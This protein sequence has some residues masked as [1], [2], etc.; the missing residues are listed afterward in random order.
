MVAGNKV[1]FSFLTWG[2][3]LVTTE[4]FSQAASYLEKEIEIHPSSSEAH[5]LLGKAYWGMGRIK[6]AKAAWERAASL[7]PKLAP[8]VE[9]RLARLNRLQKLLIISNEVN[10]EEQVPPFL[11][12]DLLSAY[13]SRL[14]FTISPRLSGEFLSRLT[15]SLDALAPLALDEVRKMSEA[16]IL[17]LCDTASY[18]EVQDFREDQIKATARLAGTAIDLHHHTRLASYQALRTG[19][20]PTLLEAS[21]AAL[22]TAA[23]RLA[24]EL[25]QQIVSTEALRPRLAVEP[26]DICLPRLTF[27]QGSRV[28]FEVTVHNRGDEEARSFQVNVWE[29]QPGFPKGPARGED[30]LIDSFQVASLP[31]LSSATFSLEWEARTPGLNQIGVSIQTENRKKEMKGQGQEAHREVLVLS[32]DQ[33]LEGLYRLALSYTSPG[34]Q[35]RLLLNAQLKVA[36]RPG[37]ESSLRDL[38]KV[39]IDPHGS[40]LTAIGLG[41]RPWNIFSD[42]VAAPM[43][44]RAAKVDAQNWLALIKGA[45]DRPAH[46]TGIPSR[47]QVYGAHVVLEQLLPDGSA[48]VKVQ[49]PLH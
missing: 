38:L 5:L 27:P 36:L 21:R 41:I 23:D 4:Q 15:S 30:R 31:P 32:R 19:S 6:D 39:A 37:D 40:L 33:I 16:D 12:R 48:M 34:S 46:E 13:F 7:E 29:R 44:K 35:D 26:E 24:N 2:R 18:L 10:A 47:S 43:A 28:A 45:R 20:A 14:G 25:L 8:L 42:E 22:K 3:A 11:V 1:G 49:M 17:I 9:A